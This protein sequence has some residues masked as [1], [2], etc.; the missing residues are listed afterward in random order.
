L[1]SVQSQGGYAVAVIARKP[2]RRAVPPVGA[3]S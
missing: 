2:T 1:A 3:S